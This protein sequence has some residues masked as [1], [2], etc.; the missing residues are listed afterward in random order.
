MAGVAV[1][2]LMDIGV[3]LV[4]SGLMTGGPQGTLQA[5]SARLGLLKQPPLWGE[6]FMALSLSSMQPMLGYPANV[7]LANIK[8]S[9]LHCTSI[10]SVLFL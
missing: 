8:K 4:L 2:L 6:Q 7:V 10:P 5:F 1:A 9:L 3:H